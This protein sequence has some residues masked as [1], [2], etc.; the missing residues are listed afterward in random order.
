VSPS[1]SVVL[2]PARSLRINPDDSNG[3][4]SEIVAADITALLPGH[5]G[6]LRWPLRQVHHRQRAAL[7]DA[8]ASVRLEQE[9]AHERLAHLDELAALLMAGVT[10]GSLTVS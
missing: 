9:R 3:L 4:L 2:F 6:W 1:T 10:A 5:R 7:A 8:L